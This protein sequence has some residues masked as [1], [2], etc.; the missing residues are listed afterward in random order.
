MGLGVLRLVILEIVLFIRTVLGLIQEI[1][2][3]FF[4]YMDMPLA[5]L[6][7]GVVL[8]LQEVVVVHLEVLKVLLVLA[9]HH[10]PVEVQVVVQE[11]LYRV[12][13]VQE[14]RFHLHMRAE[15]ALLRVEVV[16]QNLAVV[17]QVKVQVLLQ[18]AVVQVQV[19]QVRLNLV[20]VL[21][22]RLNLV[23]VLVK[24]LRHQKEVVVLHRDLAV[25]LILVV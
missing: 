19:L 11:V 1:M 2:I 5:H 7:V 20:Q 24:V 4:I 18:E 17:H 6:Q 25:L 13:A 16:L 3:G 12:V 14:V 23:Q 22:V 10:C 21:Q 15:V 8:N 9:N